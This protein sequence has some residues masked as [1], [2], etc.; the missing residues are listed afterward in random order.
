[1]GLHVVQLPSSSVQVMSERWEAHV[2]YDG[3]YYSVPYRFF[4]QS[5]VMHVF[6]RKIEVFSKNGERIA[7]HQRKFS[8]KRYSTITEHMPPNHQAVV[9]FRSFDGSYYRW[10]SN[11]IG[12]CTETFVKTLLE[13]ADF[14]EQAYKSCMGVLNFSRTYGNARVERACEKAI[15]LHSVTY[16]TLKNILKNGQDLQPATVNADADTPTPYH[17]NLRVGEWK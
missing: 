7:I 4:K 1:M 9:A 5:V 6:A 14:E 16:T 3:F 12:P 13:K 8:G 2:E 15:R 10:K 11:E 17:E